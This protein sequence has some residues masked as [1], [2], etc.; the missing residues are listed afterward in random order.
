MQTVDFFTPIVD[1]PYDFGRVAA[2]NALS[3]IFAMGG[4][5]ILA[6]NI[7]CF[8]T[9][10]LGTSTLTRILQGGSDIVQAAGAML[11]G[12]HSIAD[13][14]LKY[15]LAVTGT[16]HPE[17]F[18]R[19]G[20]AQP[21]DQLFLT[22][23]LGTGILATLLKRE[24]LD[25]NHLE[26]LVSTMTTLNAGAARAGRS[27]CGRGANAVDPIHAV[28]DI[29]G[30]GLLGHGLEMARASGVHLHLNAAAIPVLD[31]ALA[32]AVEGTCTGG[33]RKNRAHVGEL[34][35]IGQDIAPGLDV[36]LADPQ[37]SGGLLM[38]VAA[39]AADDLRSALQEAETLAVAC[40]GEAT[41]GPPGLT[42][43]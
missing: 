15:G 16:V 9:E 23:P 18:W 20:G 2:A 22:K 33:G 34:A 13:D 25:E 41:D 29:T 39:S 10:K 1:D 37:T 31:G 19:N 26:R 5:P 35:Q 40:I 38:A 11:G 32:A 14:E 30:F 27:L 7:V 28:T 12:G 42:V 3:D 36:L 24:Q 43:S 4:E 17:R 8:P 6:V 21:G